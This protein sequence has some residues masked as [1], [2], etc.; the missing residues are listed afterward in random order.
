[1][2]SS[3]NE[4]WIILQAR[5]GSKRLPGKIF[6][7]V[8]GKTLLEY[9]IERLKEIPLIKGLIVATTQLP[10][11]DQVALEYE[12]LGVRIFRGDENDVLSRYTHAAREVGAKEIVRTTADCPLIDPD[13][14]HQMLQHFASLK[15]DYMSNNRIKTFPHGL[16]AEVFTS[17]ALESAYSADTNAE[18]RE[19][20]SGYITDHPEDFVC[21]NFANPDDPTGHM[22][23]WQ[24]RWTVDYPE[25]FAL[26]EKILTELYPVNP[27][28]RWK[29]VCQILDVHPE[30]TKLNAKY[31]VH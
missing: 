2:N 21:A 30:W 29:E 10:Q 19:H 13:V 15:P 22:N 16:D 25:D 12:R 7:K 24:H 1:M 4:R 8:L 23:F 9:Q 6:K 11:D 26:I 27:R 5:M 28:F 3:S 14:I 20:V 18:R 31:R 17:S